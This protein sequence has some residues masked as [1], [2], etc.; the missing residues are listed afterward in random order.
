MWEVLEEIEIEGHKAAIWRSKDCEGR[1]IYECTFNQF[2][3]KCEPNL[4]SGF[5][6]KNLAI[7]LARHSVLQRIKDELK[8][9]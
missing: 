5:V 9:L 2:G 7:E 4:S 1:P 6:T 3:L 8:Y